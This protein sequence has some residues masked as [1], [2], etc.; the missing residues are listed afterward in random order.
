MKSGFWQN[1][2]LRIRER[3][4]IGRRNRAWANY[5]HAKNVLIE[6]RDLLKV[7]NR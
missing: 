3:F 4:W 1:A 2:W 6:I 5:S 7:S